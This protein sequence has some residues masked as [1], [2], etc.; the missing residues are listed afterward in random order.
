MALHVC[1]ISSGVL[2]T[3]LE[4]LAYCE[5][6]VHSPLAISIVIYQEANTPLHHIWGNFPVPAPC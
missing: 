4:D 2:C 6:S 1:S 3:Y 5:V